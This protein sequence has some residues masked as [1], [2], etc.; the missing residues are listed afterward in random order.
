MHCSRAIREPRRAFVPNARGRLLADL[1][2][3]ARRRLAAARRRRRSTAAVDAP[4]RDRGAL[5]F[6]SAG[7]RDRPAGHA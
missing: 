2:V 7:R 4:L 6:A 3:L 5:L 1:A